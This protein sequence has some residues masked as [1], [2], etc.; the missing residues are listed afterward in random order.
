MSNQQYR[1]LDMSKLKFREHSTIS[2]EEALK[3]VTPIKWSQEVLD[4]K[5]KVF[6]NRPVVDYENN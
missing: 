6:I 3:D 4:G 2:T 5:K 1:K